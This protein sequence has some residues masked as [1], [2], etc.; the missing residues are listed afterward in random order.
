MSEYPHIWFWRKR[1]PGRKDQRC[2]ILV[3][4]G[5]NSALIEFKDGY[6][7][8]V[9]RNALRKAAMSN[10]VLHFAARKAAQGIL[11]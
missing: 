9:S 11:I 5:M 4:G 7:A 3:R 1:L 2:R 6:K 8:V 10:A